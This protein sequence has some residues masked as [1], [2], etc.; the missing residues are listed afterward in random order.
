M[1]LFRAFLIK[2]AAAGH[3]LDEVKGN[4]CFVL[5]CFGFLVRL[6]LVAVAGVETETVSRE[7]V[8]C[9]MGLGQ[10]AVW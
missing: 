9:F 3:K 5:F 4:V 1:G 10:T 7:I 2:T 8:K 6:N